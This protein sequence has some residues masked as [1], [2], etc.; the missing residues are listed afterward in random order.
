MESGRLYGIGMPV[1]A[2]NYRVGLV[3]IVTLHHVDQR[4]AH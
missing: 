3:E 2:Y 4:S 1:P